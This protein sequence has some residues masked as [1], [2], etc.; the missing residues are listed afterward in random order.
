[1]DFLTT[2]SG[3]PCRKLTARMSP[4]GLR[5]RQVLQKIPKVWG[6]SEEPRR[7]VAAPEAW[8]LVLK[9]GRPWRSGSGARPRSWCSWL[10]PSVVC[11]PSHG[12]IPVVSCSAE[13]NSAHFPAPSLAPRARCPHPS[14]LAW[15]VFVIVALAQGQAWLGASLVGTVCTV[16]AEP[17]LSSYAINFFLIWSGWGEGGGREESPGLCILRG[18]SLRRRNHPGLLSP[19]RV[20]PFLSSAPRFLI[21]EISLYESVLTGLLNL[22][23]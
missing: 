14:W 21:Q 16:S 7:T 5:C 10:P 19:L 6:S 3:G 17:T 8:G 4:K 15:P 23:S 2:L 1:M 20:A 11:C 13:P 12:H 22:H 18:C 9:G